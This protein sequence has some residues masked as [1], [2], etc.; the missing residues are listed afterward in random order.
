MSSLDEFFTFFQI[1][2]D[3]EGW[4]IQV[5]LFF[6]FSVIGWCVESLYISW[7]NKK[8][9]NRGFLHAPIC[10][11]YGF[12]E[13]IGFRLLLLLPHNYIVIFVV[14]TVFATG[15]EL[16]VAQFMIYKFGA[17][18][19]DYT[20]R[21]FNYK[22]ILCLESTLAWG[23]YAVIEVWFL[24]DGLAWLSAQ[25]PYILRI[26]LFSLLGAYC[27]IDLIFV[28]IKAK[29]EGIQ[30]EANNMLIVERKPKES[31]KAKKGEE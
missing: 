22:G 18:W 19:W 12:A 5:G 13:F 20:N 21:P 10:P 30:A 7:M 17:V 9:T 3:L 2:T 25:I 4:T 27:I 14:G 15:V 29:K 24:H 6:M 8:W 26:I 1:P 28:S 16:L 23:V 11:I 31:K